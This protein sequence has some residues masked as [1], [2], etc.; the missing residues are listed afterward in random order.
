MRYQRRH[1]LRAGGGRGLDLA[2]V[3]RPRPA[4]ATAGGLAGLRHLGRGP[5]GRRHRPRTV[6]A[7]AD[8]RPHG[9]ANA[10]PLAPCAAAAGRGGPVHR[11]GRGVPVAARGLPPGRRPAA[12]V[13][14]TAGRESPWLGGRGHPDLAGGQRPAAER[15]GRPRRPQLLGPQ[16]HHRRGRRA[17]HQRAAVGRPGVAGVVGVARPPGADHRRHRPDGR[18]DR[19]MERVPGDGADPRLRRHPLCHRR[20]GAG[21]A[22]RARTWSGQGG[23]TAPTC[24]SPPP[25]A[26]AGWTR[27]RSTASST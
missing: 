16:H 9:R 20:R 2:G 7:G 11:A 21:R 4:P 23:S 8:P 18:R 24:W 15:A 25:P 5:A 27:A 10:Q 12:A 17:D 26:A 22:R 3:R 19:R 13:D 6:V 14:G 1:R